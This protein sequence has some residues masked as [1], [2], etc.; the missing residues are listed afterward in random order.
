[1]NSRSGW[2]NHTREYLK[3]DQIGKK[4]FKVHK[5]VHNFD[6]SPKSLTPINNRKLDLSDHQD[7]LQIKL[8]EIRQDA[9]L[10]PN[11]GRIIKDKDQEIS[12]LRKMY[13]EAT[14]KL[15]IFETNKQSKEEEIVRPS[16]ASASYKKIDINEMR[17]PVRQG[18]I[19]GNYSVRNKSTH[20]Y[21][22][23]HFQDFSF[24][25]SVRFT[26]NRPKIVLGNPI[27]GIPIN[28][29]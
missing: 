17:L 8:S 2:L 4:F 5:N 7:K 20:N 3:Q 14:S 25:N 1:M 6:L 15:K 16:L 22:P 28:L 13:K 27:T 26:K 19:S 18:L 9:R 23:E 29:P 24:L 11:L 12:N 21:R 10:T